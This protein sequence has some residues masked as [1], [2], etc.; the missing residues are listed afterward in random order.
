MRHLLVSSLKKKDSVSTKSHLVS[1]PR[2]GLGLIQI[3]LDFSTRILLDLNL[4]GYGHPVALDV[5]G[6]DLL[7]IEN[8]E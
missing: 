5:I 4:V 6:L 8:K 2:N 7:D 3:Q 1:T